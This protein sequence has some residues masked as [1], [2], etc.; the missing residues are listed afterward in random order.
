[1]T[2]GL[3][4]IERSGAPESG[5]RINFLDIIP[6]KRFNGLAWG[7]LKFF[8]SASSNHLSPGAFGGELRGKEVAMQALK[9]FRLKPSSDTLPFL[10]SL[11][12]RYDLGLEGARVGTLADN[13]H[14]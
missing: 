10:R 8:T 6:N 13:D 9:R 5:I 3:Y 1:M 11:Y 4:P 7:A 14:G 2:S 12:L